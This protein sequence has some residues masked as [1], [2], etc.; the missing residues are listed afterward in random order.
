MINALFRPSAASV[1][2]Y[3]TST[4][5]NEI[6]TE[7]RRRFSSEETAERAWSN[8]FWSHAYDEAKVAALTL[9]CGHE[10]FWDTDPQVALRLSDW[11]GRYGA[12]SEIAIGQSEASS[13]LLRVVLGDELSV[14]TKHFLRNGVMEHTH[15]YPS[16]QSL[17]SWP[18]EV[19]PYTD[20]ETSGPFPSI[21]DLVEIFIRPPKETESD[22]KR[23]RILHPLGGNLYTYQET[24][25]RIGISYGFSASGEEVFDR[26]AAMLDIISRALLNE[27]RGRFEKEGVAISLHRIPYEWILERRYDLLPR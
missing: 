24:D 22:F 21:A 9:I 10:G 14:T 7:M 20:N 15:P 3:P 27:Y 2:E 13:R 19:I 11:I 5:S 1:G 25:R 4:F 16:H 12:S 23:R 17:I 6:A 18:S 8:H 26:F